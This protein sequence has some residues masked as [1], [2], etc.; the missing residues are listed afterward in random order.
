MATPQ[1]SIFEFHQA[2]PIS[3]LT[4]L[5]GARRYTRYPITLPV[6]FHSTGR[7][8]GPSGAGVT[9]DFSSHDMFV[10]VDREKPS[11]GSRVKLIVE[12][13]ALLDGAVPLQFIA[14]GQ[15]VRRD[16]FGF[17][18]RML[19]HEY[20]TRRKEVTVLPIATRAASRVS[21]SLKRRPSSSRTPSTRK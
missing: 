13:P 6:R 19:R 11:P 1:S 17:A 8:K 10:T 7:V 14:L 21:P 9:R 16:A 12:W 5:K 18:V 4:L 20:R 2:K 15:V 3:R